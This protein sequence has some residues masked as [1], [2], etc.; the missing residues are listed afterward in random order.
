[1]RHVTWDRIY[2]STTPALKENTVANVQT[3]HTIFMRARTVGDLQ[4]FLEEV[5]SYPGDLDNHPL[6]DGPFELLVELTLEH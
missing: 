5:D 1:V 3:H 6:I 4:K 2:T